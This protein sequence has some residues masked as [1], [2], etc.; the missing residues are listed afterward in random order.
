[1][2]DDPVVTPA[3]VRPPA[4][5]T[6][7]LTWASTLSQAARGVAMPTLPGNINTQE[8]ALLGLIP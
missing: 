6:V 2:S 1:M 4:G 8:Q 5:G 3:L 7:A